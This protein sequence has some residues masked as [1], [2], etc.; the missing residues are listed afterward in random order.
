MCKRINK[1]LKNMN[2]NGR[3]GM[4][5]SLLRA[6][7]DIGNLQPLLAR[8]ESTAETDLERVT[9]LK[10]KTLFAKIADEDPTISAYQSASEEDAIN[11]LC[12]DQLKFGADVPGQLNDKT[13]YLMKVAIE[14]YFGSLSFRDNNPGIESQSP[15]TFIIGPLAR[16]HKLFR[17]GRRLF[18]KVDTTAFDKQRINCLRDCLFEL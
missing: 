3:S 7:L 12:R 11:A 1:L 4:E 16:F 17:F 14:K 13:K 2:W 8:M 18:K 6:F 9:V 10:M 5:I 15:D